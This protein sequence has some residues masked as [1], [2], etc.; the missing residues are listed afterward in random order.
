VKSLKNSFFFALLAGFVFHQVTVRSHPDA[1]IFFFQKTGRKGLDRAVFI[2]KSGAFGHG[3]FQADHN[4]FV[5]QFLSF[6]YC[7][8]GFVFQGIMLLVL[9]IIL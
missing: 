7:P 9:Q 6:N 4:V 3:I 2:I 1:A 8:K 5:S